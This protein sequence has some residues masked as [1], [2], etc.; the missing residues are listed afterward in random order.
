MMLTIWNYLKNPTYTP[1]TIEENAQKWQ[2][3]RR[4]LFLAIAFSIGLGLTIDAITEAFNIDLGDHGIETLIEKYS[5]YV[6]LIFVVILAPILEE[7]IFRAPLVLFKNFKYYNLVFYLSVIV[8]GAVHLSNFE[9][10]T[11]YL[12]LAPLIV[13]PQLAAG[14]FLGYT[15]VKLGL[16][17]SILLHALHNGILFLPFMI[18]T[19]LEESTK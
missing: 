19:V 10:Y 3:F 15:R 7:L 18:F 17:Y 9:L 8:F 2:I 12:W 4:I 6:L 5:I 16:F 1:F 13:A 11:N 14:V